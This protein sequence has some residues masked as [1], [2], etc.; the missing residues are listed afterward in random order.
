MARLYWRAFCGEG[1]AMLR[2][3][4]TYVVLVPATALLAGVSTVVNLLRPGGDFTMRMGRVWSRWM[5]ATTGARVTYEGLDH[6]AVDGPCVFIANHASNLDIWVVFRLL[7]LSARFVAKES[8]FRI[9]LLGWAL[10]SAGFIPIDRQHRGSAIRSLRLAAERIRSG[11]PVILFAEGTRTR[12]GRL[13]KF[14]RGPFHLALQAGVPVIPVAI[15]GSYRVMPPR[16]LRVSP[17]PVTVRVLKPVD[18]TPYLPSDV[19]GL[20][21]VV[22][23]GVKNAVTP[24]VLEETGESVGA[25]GS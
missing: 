17:G 7:P 10:R 8:L 1:E 25:G 4:L 11:R 3:L 16:T 21:E 15:S 6:A 5:L 20:L 22:Y 13:G 19:A 18:V 2:G 12:T 23:E 14:K 24:D 9:P